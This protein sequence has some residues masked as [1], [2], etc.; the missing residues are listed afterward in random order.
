LQVYSISSSV[1]GESPRKDSG[2]RSWFQVFLGCSTAEAVSRLC[3]GGVGVE[4]CAVLGELMIWQVN[5]PFTDML[6]AC[7]SW[8]LACFSGSKREG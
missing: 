5:S 7:S 8:H 3:A 1:S 2:N 6:I 4:S